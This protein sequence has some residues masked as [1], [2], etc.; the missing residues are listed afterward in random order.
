MPVINHKDENPNNN[1]VNNLE[2]C[3]VS[4]NNNYNNRQK[5][6]G[7]KEGITI[8]VFYKNKFEKNI[9]SES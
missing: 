6:I 5:K 7:D 1:N 9:K 2:W 4:Y 3:T 8:K